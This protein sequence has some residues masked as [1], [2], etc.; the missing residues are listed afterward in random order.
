MVKGSKVLVTGGSGFLGQ[1]IIKHLQLYF[2]D[3]VEIRV[4]DLIA[5]QQRLDFDTK[6]EVK[7]YKGSITDLD[8]VCKAC[9]KVDA[10]IHAASLID[11]RFL[12]NTEALKE[13]NIKE[14]VIKACLQENVK[15]L[16]YCGSI[17]AVQGYEEVENGN[18][19]T[20][21]IPSR[22]L[23]IRDYGETK[24]YAQ[25]LVKNA[26]GKATKDG[27]ILH[28]VTLLPLTMFG[29]LDTNLIT[30]ALGTAKSNHGV[31][32]RVGNGKALAQFVYV[33]NVAFAFVCALKSL[34]S[35]SDIGGQFFFISDDTHPQNTAE[36]LL[37]Y[38][39]LHHYNVSKISI[40]AYFVFL[41]ILSPVKRVSM[42]VSLSAVIFLNRTFF[43][44]YDKAR[45]LLSY[46]PIYTPAES[47]QMSSRYYA[48]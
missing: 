10:V 11:S 46:F 9:H 27:T 34:I 7:S 29:E 8:F 20:L 22:R 41:Y 18:E 43:I 31:L 35:G 39:K 40:P 3:I 23:M 1:H 16:L 33:G 13:I 47:E 48:T 17:S 25:T 30:K 19:S 36:F 45:T 14:T 44:N 26:D 15:Y 37:P 5:Y 6:V 24:Y 28:T 4:L 2:D 42:S 32:Q 38:L 21:P 12:P